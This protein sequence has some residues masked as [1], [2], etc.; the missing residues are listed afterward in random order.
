MAKW[1]GAVVTALLVVVWIGSGW[2]GMSYQTTQRW[3]VQIHSGALLLSCENGTLVTLPM[4]WRFSGDWQNPRF[5]W[6]FA[7]DEW[8]SSSG[9]FFNIGV[10]QSSIWRVCQI[11][12]WFPTLMLLVL[13][14]ASWRFDTLAHRRARQNLCPKCNYDRTG[15]AAGAVCP[16]CGRL[17]T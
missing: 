15:L 10:V 8:Q 6:R 1:G 12:L 16:E 13:S 4:G 14:V 17:P 11:P 9:P 7:Y 5:E 3:A 2:W